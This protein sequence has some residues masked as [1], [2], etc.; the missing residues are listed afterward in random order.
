MWTNFETVKEYEAKILNILFQTL[1]FYAVHIFI[2]FK[3]PNSLSNIL[4]NKNK[5]FVGNQN[6]ALFLFMFETFF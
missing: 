3:Q 1:S 6:N 2:L 4:Q 5:N